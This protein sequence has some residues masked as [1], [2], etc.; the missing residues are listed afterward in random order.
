M[1]KVR[2]FFF[3]SEPSKTAT[4]KVTA[5]PFC[6]KETLAFQYGPSLKAWDQPVFLSTKIVT[7][8]LVTP[9]VSD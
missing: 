1:E 7:A 5:S 2:T 4:H 3:E 6:S 9:E 8:E